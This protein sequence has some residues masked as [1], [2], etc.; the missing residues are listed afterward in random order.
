MC[1]LTSSLIHT[2]THPIPAAASP[3]TALVQSPAIDVIGIAHLDGTV[4]VFDIRQGELV[5]QVKMD[6]GGVTSLAF[7]MGMFNPG[8][9]RD[10]IADQTDGPPILATGSS[11]GSMAMWDLSQGGKSVHVQRHA[12]EQGVAGLEWV[13]GQPLLVSSSGD[14]SVKVGRG[15]PPEEDLTFMIPL[16][17][18]YPC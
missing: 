15:V 3:V 12:H 10:A 6:D 17:Q 18:P 5:M 11:A 4:R 9:P 13:T 14:N 1:L 16:S 2:F 7:R 8:S